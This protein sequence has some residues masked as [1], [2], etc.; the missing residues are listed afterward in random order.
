MTHMTNRLMI[1]TLAVSALIGD[2]TLT[3]ATG[4][5]T[6]ET[7][8]MDPPSWLNSRRVEGVVEKIQHFMEWDIRK[9]TVIWHANEAEFL[10][11]HNFGSSVLALTL[12]RAN[13]IHIG[14]QVTTKNFDSIFGHELVHVI[15]FQKYKDSIP[16][17][18]EE[19]LANYIAQH[20]KVDYSW[21]R[22]KPSQEV[23]TLIHPFQQTSGGAIV[24]ADSSRYHYE[25]STA[26]IEMIAS[27]CDLKDL[28]G[29]SAGKKLISYLSGVCGID[30]IQTAFLLWLKK[31]RIRN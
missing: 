12:K 21:L 11:I 7:T 9:V 26:V 27:K 24:T 25:A 6:N 8:F 5:A 13:T 10:K 16:S 30:D 15:L 4:L 31:P 14:P 22:S 3:F 17:W 1:L 19:G 18:L 29:L 2:P 20:G 23:K 28:L